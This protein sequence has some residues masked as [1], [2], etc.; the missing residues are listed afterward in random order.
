MQAGMDSKVN[1]LQSQIDHQS[2]VLGDKIDERMSEQMD[3]TE[4]L[5]CK[6]SRFE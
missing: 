2:K 6:R 1:M 3:R 5:L 4:Q